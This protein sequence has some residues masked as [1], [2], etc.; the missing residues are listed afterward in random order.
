MNKKHIQF[1]E[2]KYDE[3]SVVNKQWMAV[4]C[5]KWIVKILELFSQ[6]F[7]WSYISL[8]FILYIYIYMY[9][10]YTFLKKSS[11]IKIT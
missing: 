2:K 3:S 1:Y 5:N 10:I 4:D 9:L 8:E 11:K 7:S 6:N